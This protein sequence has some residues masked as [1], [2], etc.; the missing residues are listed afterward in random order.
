[1]TRPF[2]Q[3]S[4]GPGEEITFTHGRGGG[5]RMT[6]VGDG[7]RVSNTVTDDQ[8]RQLA[9]WLTA[10]YPADAA[11]VPVAQA[12]PV[13]DALTAD[14]AQATREY[15]EFINGGSTHVCPHCGTAT[16]YQ[17]FSGGKEWYC[18]GCEADG[19]YPDGV[20]PS[21]AGLL[22]T[23]EGRAALRQQMLDHLLSMGEGASGGAQESE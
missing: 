8:A 14:V 5:L 22:A 11:P 6:M 21:R 10:M 20:A 12:V 18:P 3:I 19:S 13:P 15:G 7:E 2:F 1:M 23:D 4:D 9:G 17:L 16:Q